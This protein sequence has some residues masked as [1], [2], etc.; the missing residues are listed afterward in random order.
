MAVIFLALDMYVFKALYPFFDVEG[1]LLKFSL[2]A[3]FWLINIG[4]MAFLFYG[5]STFRQSKAESSLAMYALGAYFVIFIPKV[6]IGSFHLVD[7][8]YN[9][10]TW[11][12]SKIGTG[13]TDWSRRNFITKVGLG[14]GA[15]MFGG[16]LYG[17]T[18][19]KFAWR[20]LENTVSS[21]R[22]PKQFD[23]FKI[24]QLS[25]AHLGS[26][27]RNYEPVKK[28]VQM[29]NELEPDL[30][31]FTGDMVNEHAQEAEG[32]EPVF[33][34]MN[35]KYGKY[36]IFGNHDYGYYGPWNDDEAKRSV[37]LLK[38]VNQNMGFRMLED[39]NVSISKDGAQM[40]L[41]G[42][43]NWGRSRHFPKKGDVKKALSGTAS[44]EFKI[45]MSHD[46]THFEDVIMGKEP[47]DLTLSGHTHG[48]QM[49]I[50]IPS[51]GIKYSPVKH[52]Y[53]RWAGLYKEGEQ[54]LHVNRG[55][56]VLAFPGRIGMA[57]EISLITL[58]TA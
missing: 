22:L 51:L 28:M 35:A 31:L 17:V 52:I 39:E 50:E 33:S 30:I 54:F 1:R 5:M 48:M 45:L 20:V 12:F 47:I 49:G 7:D 58:R 43:H 18:K 2:I 8:V 4:L 13:E 55:M 38:K 41:L 42:V 26:F 37:D 44:E 10:V 46:P 11:G 27:V 3:G 32:W 40:R 21:S 36:S 19:G 29:V 6:L 9:L 15:V 53:S 14:L 24:V 34:Q 57:P 56:G 16:A 25:D 23:G